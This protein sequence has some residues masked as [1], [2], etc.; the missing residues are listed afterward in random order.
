ML[1]GAVAVQLAPTLS[2]FPEAETAS[3]LG[4]DPMPPDS[5]L[6][7]LGLVQT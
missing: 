3:T 5:R 2:T 6:H 7:T 4:D 1:Q